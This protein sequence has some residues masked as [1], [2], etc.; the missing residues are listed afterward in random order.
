M[1]A[2]KICEIDHL[3]TGGQL[4]LVVTKVLTLDKMGLAAPSL[5]TMNSL[6]AEE[7]SMLL[8]VVEA[9]YNVDIVMEHTTGPALDVAIALEFFKRIV[10]KLF[11]FSVVWA[12]GGLR[13]SF[14][15][16]LAN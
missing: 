11:I 15:R 5:P 9:E 8:G 16:L 4:S 14:C 2:S 3:G 12:E 7:A 6:S 10:M 13:N 1:F